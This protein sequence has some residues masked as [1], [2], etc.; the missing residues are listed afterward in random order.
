M[1]CTAVC[2]RIDTHRIVAICICLASHYNLK[3]PVTIFHTLTTTPLFDAC[4]I[5]NSSQSWYACWN[6]Y[7]L[8]GY[9]RTALQENAVVKDA[10]SVTYLVDAHI[11]PDIPRSHRIKDGCPNNS[12]SQLGH[13]IA[14]SP[15]Q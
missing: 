10:N 4:Q 8:A 2:K 5:H 9:L 6:A 12:S 1:F 14:D 7:H 3:Q 11:S 13:H 15:H